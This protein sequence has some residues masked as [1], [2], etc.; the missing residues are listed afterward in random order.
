M[1]ESENFYIYSIKFL[2]KFLNFFSKRS[3]KKADISKIQ[4]PQ[5]QRLAT[6]K[7]APGDSDKDLELADEELAISDDE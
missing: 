6:G 1:L 3:L 2:I 5:S 7:R 4:S